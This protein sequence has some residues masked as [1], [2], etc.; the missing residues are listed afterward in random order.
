[1][2]ESQVMALNHLHL[3]YNQMWLQKKMSKWAQKV[4]IKKALA[5]EKHGNFFGA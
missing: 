1:M 2:L 4:L 5:F 3:P